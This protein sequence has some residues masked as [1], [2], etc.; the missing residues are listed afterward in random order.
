MK[1]G[2]KTWFALAFALVLLLTF[3]TAPALKAKERGNYYG[4]HFPV[5]P[6]P[7]PT[8]IG[9]VDGEHFPVPPP[10]PPPG[11]TDDGVHFPVPPPPPPNGY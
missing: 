10:P 4:E 7:P 9:G 1:V 6:P 11:V 5:P 2:S 3:V 8:T